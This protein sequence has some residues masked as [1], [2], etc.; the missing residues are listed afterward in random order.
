MNTMNYLERG[1]KAS[2]LY[3][4]FKQLIEKEHRM[5]LPLVKYI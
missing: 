1:L 5:G 3:F 4:K 2:K